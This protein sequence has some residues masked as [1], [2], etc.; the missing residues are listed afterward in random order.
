MLSATGQHCSSRK[1]AN[2]SACALRLWHSPA[3]VVRLTI[4]QRGHRN[5]VYVRVNPLLYPS[6]RQQGFIGVAPPVDALMASAAATAAESRAAKLRNLALERD[7]IHAGA[8]E[9][10]Q[11]A[12]VAMVAIG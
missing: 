4:L 12:V 5:C 6:I 9:A 10:I 7:T 1:Y 8:E 11:Q 3:R 2:T